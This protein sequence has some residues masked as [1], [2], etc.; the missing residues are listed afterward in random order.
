MFTIL[1]Y[2]FQGRREIIGTVEDANGVHNLGNI[3]AL[4]FFLAFMIG[5][6]SQ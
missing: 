3:E 6:I 1:D 4:R 2:L 5:I